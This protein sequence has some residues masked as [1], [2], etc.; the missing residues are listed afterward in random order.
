MPRKRI[1]RIPTV[2]TRGLALAQLSPEARRILK[3]RTKREAQREAA[4]ILASDRAAIR[5]ANRGYGAEKRSILGATDMVQN[6][7]SQALRGLKGSGLSGGYLRQV[8]NDLTS[9]QGD[10]AASIPFLLADAARERTEEVGEAR[11]QLRSDRAAMQ[12]SAASKFNQL[13]KEERGKASGVVK[14]RRE[15][16]DSELT[17]DPRALK[18]A[19]LAA[20]T[21]Y[22]ELL[23]N[24]GTRTEEGTE[25]HPPWNDQEWRAFA[26]TVAKTEGIDAVDAANA[27]K[28]L[29]RRIQGQVRKGNVRPLGLVFRGG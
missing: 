26:L 13:L 4:P 12:Q 27:V 7:L 25:I 11:A 18:I 21:G 16:T 10:A 20:T 1:P 28:I 24:A 23:K 2:G 15:G 9:R 19:M 5:D 14:A 6:S 29:W 17:S 8:Q 3:R 22:Q